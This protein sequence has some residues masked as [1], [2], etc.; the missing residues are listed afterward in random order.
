MVI[1]LNKKKFLISG[2]FKSFEDEYYFY[3]L[4]F[5]QG[6]FWDKGLKK[7]KVELPATSQWNISSHMITKAK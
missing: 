3:F 1:N 7:K 5:F 6:Q 2:Q 4:F